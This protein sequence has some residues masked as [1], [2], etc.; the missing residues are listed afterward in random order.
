MEVQRQIE[1]VV[2]QD[3]QLKA[4][5]DKVPSG[6]E[7]PHQREMI[8]I[9]KVKLYSGQDVNQGKYAKQ[10]NNQADDAAVSVGPGFAPCLAL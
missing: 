4:V 5:S 8:R 1:D 10:K 9:R 3:E 7:Y 6:F 2:R